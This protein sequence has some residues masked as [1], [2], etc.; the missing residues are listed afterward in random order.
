M[1]Q[2]SSVTSATLQVSWEKPAGVEIEAVVMGTLFGIFTISKHD[3][4]WYL[5]AQTR[6]QRHRRTLGLPWTR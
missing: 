4:V 5:R 1:E 6:M 3:Y 2:W